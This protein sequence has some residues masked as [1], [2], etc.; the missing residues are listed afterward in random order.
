MS[1]EASITDW[2]Q[3]LS[4][5]ATGGLAVATYFLSRGMYHAP[6]KTFLRPIRM[7]GNSEYQPTV[8][9]YNV[10][11]GIAFNVS[12]QMLYYSKIQRDPLDS[13]LAWLDDSYTN[14]AGP[15]EIKQDTYAE[16]SF[17]VNRL[18]TNDPLI[19]YWETITGKRIKTYWKY[20]R[21][22]GSEDFTRLSSS[23]VVLF[24]IKR[25]IINVLSPVQ[26]VRRRYRFKQTEKSDDT[27]PKQ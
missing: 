16:Y 14:A 10:G 22:Y 13:Q 3:A 25:I 27:S 7:R 9:L 18:I 11:P 5:I 19:I 17:E 12:V 15:G 4:G 20:G 8:T 6:F 2:I 26:K 1:S 23:Q 24:K 21:T